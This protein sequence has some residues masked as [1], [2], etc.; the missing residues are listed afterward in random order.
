[1]YNVGQFVKITKSKYPSLIVHK[2]D[3][4]ELLV[5]IIEFN[6]NYTI[7]DAESDN[8]KLLYLEPEEELSIIS[9]FGD[10]YYNHHQLLYIEIIIKNIKV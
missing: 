6:G 1:M 3:G 4:N 8:I 9:S 7:V 10:W 2:M 5:S